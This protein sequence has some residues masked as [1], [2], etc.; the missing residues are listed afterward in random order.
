MKKLVVFIIVTVIVGGIVSCRGLLSTGRSGSN[1]RPLSEN[2][3]IRHMVATY[4]NDMLSGGIPPKNRVVYRSDY[5][6]VP[7]DTVIPKDSIYERFETYAGGSQWLWKF[8]SPDMCRDVYQLQISS[9]IPFPITAEG[10][11]LEMALMI[12]WGPEMYAR[13]IICRSDTAR[14]YTSA[15]EIRKIGFEEVGHNVFRMRFRPNR[16]KIE[17]FWEI[18]FYYKDTA[19]Y[20]PKKIF[21]EL[22]GLPYDKPW[23]M[24]RLGFLQMADSAYAYPEEELR[25]RVAFLVRSSQSRQG[26][27]TH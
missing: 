27:G 11:S 6:V 21:R 7:K 25:E 4:R 18:K 23:A 26:E 8:S 20:E 12:P 10:L 16:S 14:Y 24:V 1:Q 19:S 15:E 3:L 5:W 9:S 22:L 13:E 2:M 17:K